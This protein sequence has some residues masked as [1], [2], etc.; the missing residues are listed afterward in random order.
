MAEPAT[1]V[2]FGAS[3]DLTERKLV[4]ALF[5]NF[6]KRRLAPETR[7]VGVS[8]SQLSD[9][10]FREKLFK[11]T[12]ST[13]R[14]E[15]DEACWREFAQRI[16]YWAG[17]ITKREDC[18]R[19]SGDLDQL[20]DG[21]ARGRLYYLALAP[22]L[23]EAAVENL[24]ATGL[25]RE[26]GSW[27]RVVFEKPFGHDG[28]SAA[29][30][31]RLIH[32]GFGEKQVFR[33]DHYLGK[34]TVQN[35]LTLR[36][37]NAIFE[38]VWNRNYIDHVQITVA[39]S[40]GV[41]RRGAYYDQAGVLRDM[42]QNHVMQLLTLTAMEPP[43]AF[44]ADAL[45]DEKVKVLRAV[46]PID[47]SVRGQYGKSED[48]TAYR[49]EPDVASDTDTANYA[50]LRLFV[51]NWRWRDV[52]FYLRSGK[53]LATKSTAIAIEFRCVPHLLFPVGRREDIPPNVLYICIQPDEGIRLRLQAK[54]PG[55]GMQVRTTHIDYAYAQDFAARSLPDAYERLLLDAIHGDAALFTRADEIELAWTI[56]DPVLER[57]TGPDGPPLRIYEPGS[58]G[59]EQA[60][61]FLE[62]DGRHWHAGCSE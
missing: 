45:R 1:I 56:I 49:R 46:R 34:E 9:D 55:A 17:D 54:Q 33:I 37:A 61:A 24:G 29:E 41:G 20:E 7:I 38:P 16:H 3:G 57:W 31:N 59:P 47:G 35:V 12:K 11:Q 6:Q 30:L 8:R 10:D 27:R 39:E 32:Q 4:P 44:E 36:F 43:V 42:F 19:L 13:L 22:Q 5:D 25:A 14:D 28:A 58:W 2:I 23:F 62:Q 18:D 51:D 15:C 52:P 26:D 48:V 53:R 60:D 21:T 40:V 50:A